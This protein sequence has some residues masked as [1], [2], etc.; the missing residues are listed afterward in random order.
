MK[1]L[2][3]GAQFLLDELQ[4]VDGLPVLRSLPDL[5][6]Q[7]GLRCVGEG[8]EGECCVIPPRASLRSQ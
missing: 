7:D 6:A 4:E 5:A 1:F 2:K 3:V 8:G